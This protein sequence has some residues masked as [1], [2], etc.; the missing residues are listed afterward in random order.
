MGVDDILERLVGHELAGLLDDRQGRLV[1]PRGL[2]DG[3]I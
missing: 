1:V 3:S 2:Y